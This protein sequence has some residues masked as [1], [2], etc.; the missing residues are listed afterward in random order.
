MPYLYCE[1]CGQ[2]KE[3]DAF[4]NK[5]KHPG[6]YTLIAKGKVVH[7][8]SYDYLCDRCNSNLIEGDP[9]I[10]VEFCVQGIPEKSAYISQFFGNNFDIVRY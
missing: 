3:S 2:N 5:G 1:N 7:P 9:A 10:Y 8:I 6:E 4:K